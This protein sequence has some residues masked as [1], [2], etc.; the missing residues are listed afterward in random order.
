MMN[1]IAKMFCSS[2]RKFMRRNYFLLVVMLALI[3][4]FVTSQVRAQSNVENGDFEAGNTGFTSEYTYVANGPG[5]SEL[6]PEGLY[7]VHSNPSDLHDDFFNMG[8]HTTGSGL[9]MIINGDPN[10]GKIVWQ[11]TT[12]IDLVVGQSYNFSAWVAQ[13][14]GGAIASLTF[15]A[16]GVTISTLSPPAGGWAR[17]YGTFTAL[18]ARPTLTLTNSQPAAGGNDFAIDDINVTLTTSTT[19]STSPDPSSLGQTVTLT[20]TVFPSSA[21]GTVTFKE[22]GTTLGSAPVIGGVAT[23]QI[24]TLSAG[25]HTLRAEYGGDADHDPSSGSDS[26]EVLNVPEMDVQRPSGTIIADGTTDN[27]GDHLA[28]VVNLEYTICNLLGATLTIPS[29]GVTVANMVNCSNFTLIGTLPINLNSGNCTGLQISFNVIDH[30]PFSFDMDI[31]NNDPDENPYDITISGIG[32]APEIDVQRPAETAIPDGGTDKLGDKLIG[33]INLTYTIDNTAGS[34]VLNVTAI[35][36]SNYVNSEGLAAVTPLPL[37]VPAGATALLNIAFTAF[38]PGPFSLEMDIANNDRNE[39]PYDIALTGTAWPPPKAIFYAT[40]TMGCPGTNIHFENRS[41]GMT[42]AYWWDFGDG[43]NSDR[44]NPSHVFPLPGQYTVTLISSNPAAS[45][46]LVMPEMIWIYGY[47][48]IRWSPLTLVDNSFAYPHESWSNAIDGDFSG[49]IGTA[50]VEGV[51][52]YVKG[53]KPFAIFEF[54]DRTQKPIDGVRLISDTNIGYASRWVR[55]FQVSISTTGIADVDFITVFKGTKVGGGWEEFN[56]N[57]VDARYIKLEVITPDSG[58]RQI[59][60][61]QVCPAY[62]SIDPMRCT[63]T[64]TSPHLANGID[65]S[66]ITITLR[67]KDAN[68]ITGRQDEDFCIW[69]NP[70]P[71]LYFPVIETKSPGVYT[72]QLATLYGGS[73]EFSAS[74]NGVPLGAIPVIFNELTLVKAPLEFIK[75]SETSLNEGWDNAID[76]DIDGWDGT[77]TSGGSQC[78]AIFQFS[79]HTIKTVNKLSLLVDTGVGYESRWVERFRL[80][81][82]TTGIADADF[83]MAYDGMQKSGAWQDHVFQLANARYLK[84]V[85][86]FPAIGVRQLG[87]IEVYVVASASEMNTFELAKHTAADLAIP[88][89]FSVGSNY[90]NPFNPDTRVNFALPDSR[91][92]VAIVYNTPGQKVRTLLNGSLAAGYH[93]VTWDGTNDAGQQ[94]PSGIYYLRLQA[95]HDSMVQ[96]MIMVK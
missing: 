60:E 16:D 96:K 66:I 63:M 64:A 85:V 95:G 38:E 32:L 46:T 45:D 72:T 52:P 83:I 42:N 43:N 14:C 22:G 69:A 10:V 51:P 35:T 70:D 34:A 78:Y 21:T 67:D 12:T 58:W 68:L 2:R 47:G 88:D 27:V 81:V 44:K 57:E 40:P 8:D 71:N 18:N 19:L 41:K 1:A 28:G 48:H 23:L 4:F 92:V 91:H 75:G 86:D 56:F 77:V 15:K 53:N 3:T 6:Y 20:A 17:L 24:S 89:K 9:M 49:W 65:R 73:K 61:F 30:G 31:A 11:S 26:H 74:V 54:L 80:L 5:T 82:S 39:N 13:V 37:N 36:G 87:E 79:D 90:P 59:G 7:T 84:L 62:K 29:G 93:S 33:T 76:R 55:D 25:T 94:L 50:T